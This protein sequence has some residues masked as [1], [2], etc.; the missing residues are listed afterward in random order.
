MSRSESVSEWLVP[1]PAVALAG[2]VGQDAGAVAEGFVLPP[3]WHLVYF[4]ER[5]SP[6]DLGPE[7]HPL[8]GIP[9]PPRP[10][11]RRMFAGGRVRSIAPLAVGTSATRTTRVAEVRER[12]G[13]T[14][15][16]TIVTTESLITRD[17]GVVAVVDEQDIV[18]R[19]PRRLPVPDPATARRLPDHVESRPFEIDQARLFQFSALT[20]N[21]HRIHYDVDYCR[22]VEDYDGLVVHGPLQ[23]VLMAQ[24]AH[25]ELPGSGWKG[26]TTFSYRL[27]APVT[28]GQGLRVAVGP[29][30]FDA[31]DA[32]TSRETFATDGSGRVTA[33]GTLTAPA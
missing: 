3:M 5:P 24:A 17:D 12:S 19:E 33:V 15:D 9:Q 8:R 25:L 20:Y 4:L 21:A 18:Y 6:S 10:G 31:D 28:L 13:R 30:T 29:P 1:G 26:A 32:S 11:M 22:E 2:L 16:V 14:G 7:G 27:V 23:A